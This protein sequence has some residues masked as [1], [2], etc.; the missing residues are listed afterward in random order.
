MDMNGRTRLTSWKEI[1][2][3]LRREV[4]TVI[5]WE[6]ERGLPVHRVPGGQGRSVFAF[7]DELD[8][9]AAGEMD[10]PELPAAPEPPGPFPWRRTAGI[11]AAAILVVAGVVAATRARW[12]HEEIAS[13]SI[14]IDRVDAK[15]SEGRT[16][17][18]FKPEERVDTPRGRHSQVVDLTGDGHPEAVAALYRIADLEAP[19]PSN[20]FAFS[21]HGDLLWKQT[22]DGRLV[23]GAGEFEAP[24]QPDD[25]LTMKVGGQPLLA[26][27]L[28]H[29]TWWPSMLAVF[30]A[31]GT[32]VGT[33][34]NS[35]WLRKSL[36]TADG[37]HIITGGFSNSRNGAAFAVLD[38]RNPNGRSPEDP[39]SAY[40]CRNCP[41]GDPVHYIVVDWSDIVSALPP[42]D[43]DVV[44]TIYPNGTIELRARQRRNAEM[45]VEL[46]P[47]FEV[48]KRSV[49]D[50]FWEWHQRLEQNGTLTH[51][52]EDCPYRNG[53]IVRE[54]TPSTGWKAHGR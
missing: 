1:A 6:K 2:A 36:A 14:A 12:P 33:F 50:A 5:R 53:P 41:P 25:L 9:W 32:R 31:R 26:W 51:K 21:E 29:H 24:W 16:L 40:E 49:S 44:M 22:V 37:R 18:T 20:L 52:R 47:S 38:A 30:D 7:T 10:T 8:K 23:F 4:R 45:I 48:K 19:S 35:G 11:A 28:H 13:L 34:V 39:G 15:D 46:S 43:R 17:W 27:A 42:D 3:Y 54:W